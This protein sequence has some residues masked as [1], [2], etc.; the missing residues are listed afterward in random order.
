MK[1]LEP[2]NQCPD[3][4]DGLQARIHDPLWML[5]RQW[6]TG[7]FQADDAGS[8]VGAYLNL[9]SSPVSRYRLGLAAPTNPAKAYLREKVPLETLV[10]RESLVPESGRNLRA[11]VQAGLHFIRL[12]NASG[13]ARYASAFLASFKLQPPTAAESSA[14]DHASSNYLG[15]MAQ[16]AI[17]G[18]ALYN[19]LLPGRQTDGG[20]ALPPDA[21]FNSV[22]PADRPGMMKAASDWMKWYDNLLSQPGPNE[23]A[24]LKQ[25]MEY[26]FVVSGNTSKGE[27]PLTAPEY[28]DG[29]LDWYS[30]DLDTTQPLGA[31]DPPANSSVT[32]LP[33]PVMFR[34]MPSSRFW[35]MEDGKVNLANIEA[36]PQE[37]ARALLVSFALEFGNDWFLVPVEIQVGSL[38][39][40]RA[41]VVTNTFGEK[42]L[43]RHT[44]V[45]DGANPA[46]RMFGLSQA[47]ASDAAAAAKFADIFFLPPV[48]GLNLEA[49]PIEDVLLLRDEMANLA[50]AV[51]QTV[52]SPCGHRL[53]RHE[54]ALQPQQSGAPPA[55]AGPSQSADQKRFTYKLGSS[56]P[57]YWVP[58]LPVQTGQEVQLRRGSLPGAQTGGATQLLG[59]I[60]DPG[61]EL[62]LRDEEVPREGARITRAYQYARWS[63]GS[64][65]VW[66]GRRKQ[67]GRGEGSSGLRFD[68]L[69]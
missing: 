58:L 62:F 9:E 40:V 10:E 45:V 55:A 33:S 13:L 54:Q 46:W 52:E 68:Y 38:S 63:D 4:Q 23:S 48:L 44:T 18:I 5:A 32:F 41:L 65:H 3:M 29:T 66:V 28:R 27:M 12:L 36:A 7:E 35:E 47:Q 31:A 26:S 6:Q 20:V 16:R 49:E 56:V 60:L 43:V 15:V 11:A 34:G 69:D 59:R 67:S 8:P 57:G 50:W 42:L 14:L 64:T 17:D 19:K 51:E 22:T 37:L 24:W 1:Q 30:F 53:D 2:E 21:P 39:A 61:H 25:R